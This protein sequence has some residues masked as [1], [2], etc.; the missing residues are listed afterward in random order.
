MPPPSPAV[1]W[2]MGNWHVLLFLLN[3]TVCK[4][5]KELINISKRRFLFNF[6]NLQRKR[7]FQR[8]FVYLAASVLLRELKNLLKLYK[9]FI[10]VHFVETLI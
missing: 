4:L 6:I 8:P 10:N 2:F 7:C 9:E 1:L 3:A 5:W